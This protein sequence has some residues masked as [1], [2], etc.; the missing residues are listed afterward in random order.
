MEVQDTNRVRDRKSTEIYQR[1]RTPKRVSRIDGAI[2]AAF[3]SSAIGCLVIGMMTTGAVISEGLKN[4]LNWWGPAGPLTG[5]TG[6]GVAAWLI[7]WFILH[8]LWKN[9]EEINFGRIFTATL[10]LI[11]IGFALTFPPVFEAFE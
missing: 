10:V 3:L 1:E 5:K 6:I 7:S 4:M 9:R 11:G 2:S 8:S